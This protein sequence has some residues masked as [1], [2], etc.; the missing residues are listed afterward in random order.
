MATYN[1]WAMKTIPVLIRW[2][3]GAWDVPHYY[4]DLT[5]AVGYSSHRMGG[6]ILDEVG[7]IMS[8]LEKK[9]KCKI[10]TLNALVQNKS[11]KLPSDGFDVIKKGYSN[12]TKE[13]KVIKARLYNEQAH[14]YNW[15]WV[16]KALNLKPANIIAKPKLAMALHSSYGSG[17]EGEE[18][19]KLKEYIAKH[20]N[21][22][23]ILG[24]KVAKTEHDL[25]SGDRLDVY[26]ECK[27][28][29]HIA[30]EVKP[31]T[32]PEQDVLRGIFQCIKYKAV[33]DSERVVYNNNYENKVI[34]VIAGLMSPQNRQ[35][36]ADLGVRVI[37]KFKMR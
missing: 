14:L 11:T 36:A 34:L 4:S 13:E 18:H 29:K 10:P 2:A 24:V 7:G 8:K 37:E 23:G 16:L 25:L 3:Q 22:I 33:M 35:I 19:K 12:L 28:T 17:G 32:S 21:A 26:F 15:T 5:N 6:R 27:G 31:S 1:D 20:P 30:V 9:Y